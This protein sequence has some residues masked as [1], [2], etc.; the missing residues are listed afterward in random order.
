MA[1]AY[2]I[3]YFSSRRVLQ[4]LDDARRGRV[5]LALLDYAE[6]G[7]E[8]QG[9]D[10]SESIAFESLRTGIDGDR[11]RYEERCRTNRASGRKGGR[12][13]G[14]AENQSV[15]QKPN[16]FSKT[17]DKDKGKG[18]DEGKYN[19]SSYRRRHTARGGAERTT[20]TTAAGEQALDF[21][22]G[23]VGP[24]GSYLRREVSDA[25]AKGAAEDLI[26][27]AMERAI[28]YGGGRWAYAKSILRDAERL[29]VTDAAGYR[30]SGRPRKAA[31]P[32]SMKARSGESQKPMKN[33]FDR[34]WNAVFDDA[35]D[36]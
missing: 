2:F 20:T 31:A 12:P 18:E 22:A 28:A 15:Y 24:V 8:P 10:D 14:K 6:K 17:Q 25:L 34:D 32:G 5:I 27:L 3:V 35:P 4:K 23:N 29:G 13:S 19:D 1:Q 11:S 30:A 7:T 26:L 33:V 21:W 16:G 9:L 36:P